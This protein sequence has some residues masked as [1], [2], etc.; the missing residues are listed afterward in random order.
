MVLAVSTPISRILSQVRMAQR[1]QPA[2][3][4]VLGHAGGPSASQN[5]AVIQAAQ[6]VA[7]MD[8]ASD[9]IT[10]TV[11]KATGFVLLFR[12]GPIQNVL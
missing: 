5:L 9:G 8:R 12:G 1:L 2:Q 6:M 11:S 3:I 7:L 4:H 10:S